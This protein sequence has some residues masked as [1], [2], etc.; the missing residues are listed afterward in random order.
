MSSQEGN[1]NAYPKHISHVSREHLVILLEKL[2]EKAGNIL[3]LPTE[4]AT[5]D[6]DKQENRNC[7]MA[8]WF[9]QTSKC[10]LYS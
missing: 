7:H 10:T 6:P 5:Q 2:V 8:F 9:L 4:N 3:G 1:L